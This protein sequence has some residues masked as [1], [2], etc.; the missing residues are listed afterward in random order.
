MRRGID[1]IP[2]VRWVCLGVSCFF[3]FLQFLQRTTNNYF[4]NQWQRELLR[5]QQSPS[6]PV[7]NDGR[8]TETVRCVGLSVCA[9][10]CLFVGETFLLLAWCAVQPVSLLAVE[11][12]LRT[13]EFWSEIEKLTHLCPTGS[14]DRT[15]ASLDER[16]LSSGNGREK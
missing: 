5:V 13:M 9:C 10:V 15:P 3:F 7:E 12:S 6:L 2:V 8:S 14:H 11:A 4:L 1:F 16:L